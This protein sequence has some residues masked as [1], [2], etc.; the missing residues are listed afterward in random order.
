[1]AREWTVPQTGDT[2][3][4]TVRSPDRSRDVQ[5]PVAWTVERL[6][7]ELLPLFIDPGE[8]AKERWALGPL[9][10]EPLSPTA[11]LADVGVA[12]GSILRLEPAARWDDAAS[13]SPLT[14][15][16]LDDGR[17]PQERTQS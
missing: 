10:G 3:R 2:V 13:P 5:V 1:M 17:R 14:I 16:P 4:V 12:D 7:P 8:A 15:A 11:T 9:A 6:I